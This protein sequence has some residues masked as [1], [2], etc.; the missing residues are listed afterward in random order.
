MDIRVLRGPALNALSGGCGRID[1]VDRV[2]FNNRILR[3]INR[4]S[5]IRQQP[6][7]ALMNKTG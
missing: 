7:A 5:Y 4:L 1:R 6:E 2:G 3:Y